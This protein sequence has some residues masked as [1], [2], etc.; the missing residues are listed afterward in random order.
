MKRLQVVWFH[1]ETPAVSLNTTALHLQLF[2]Q[3]A[4][5]PFP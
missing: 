1:D 5:P 4:P 3:G 2:Q